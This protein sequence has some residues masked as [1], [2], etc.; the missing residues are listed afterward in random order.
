MTA[1]DVE[2]MGRMTPEPDREPEIA[3]DEADVDAAEAPPAHVP[4]RLER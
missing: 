1:A 4:M 3:A 2:V